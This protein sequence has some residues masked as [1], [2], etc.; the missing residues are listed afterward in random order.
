MTDRKPDLKR[1]AKEEWRVEHDV[2]FSS[3]YPAPL[4]Y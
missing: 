3:M 4:L 1:K 2:S